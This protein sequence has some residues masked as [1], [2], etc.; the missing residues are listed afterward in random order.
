MDKNK[1]GLIFERAKTIER[2]EKGSRRRRGRGREEEEK[3]RGR[4]EQ[5]GMEL[6]NFV[7][8]HVYFDHGMNFYGFQT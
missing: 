2:E 1:F 8:D 3:I 7:W 4:E 5:K 6:M